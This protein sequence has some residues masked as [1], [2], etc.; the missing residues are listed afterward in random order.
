MADPEPERLSN[1][2][3]NDNSYIEKE[4][5]AFFSKPRIFFDIKDSGPFIIY[6]ESK[7]GDPNIGRFSH[8]K[9]AREIGILNLEGIINIKNKGINR[10]AVEFNNYKKAN[11]LLNNKE[12]N[13]NLKVSLYIPPVI[14]CYNCLRY[15]HT[16]K[17]CKGKDKCFTC[18]KDK[19][20]ID[21]ESVPQLSRIRT[22]KKSSQQW[23]YKNL[24]F[25]DASQLFPRVLPDRSEEP[26]IIASN[27]PSLQQKTFNSIDKDNRVLPSQRRTYSQI[28]SQPTKKRLVQE[29]YN[30]QAHN[31]CLHSPNSRPNKESNLDA[32][33]RKTNPSPLCALKNFPPP[34]SEYNNSDTLFETN[35]NLF[36]ENYLFSKEG[37]ELKN[38]IFNKIINHIEYMDSDDKDNNDK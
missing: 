10:I 18:G 23:Q 17:T 2:N 6:I 38:R 11:D 24:S 4:K 25:I 20:D 29:G 26:N 36:I 3:N 27:F 15:G 5:V 21:K 14:Q 37:L 7:L 33:L 19:H 28:T 9:I 35:L 31:E 1:P 8:L 13:D 22:T 34:D 30:S 32:D 16:A 12:I